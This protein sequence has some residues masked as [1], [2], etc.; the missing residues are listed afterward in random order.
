MRSIV[1]ILFAASAAGCISVEPFDEAID[2]P[3]LIRVHDAQITMLRHHPQ[4]GS[5]SLLVWS[6]TSQTPLWWIQP[7]G[8]EKKDTTP[9]SF[10]YSEVPVGYVQK[11]PSGA[12]TATLPAKGDVVIFCLAFSYDTLLA[13]SGENVAVAYRYQK[14]NSWR[15]VKLPHDAYTPEGW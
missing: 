11:H 8:R 7:T 12:T 15:Q 9:L 1:A 13:A 4:K 5:P 6:Y 14:E 2:G 10:G 3:K